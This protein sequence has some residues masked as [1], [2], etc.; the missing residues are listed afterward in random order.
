MQHHLWILESNS[1]V[2]QDISSN[3]K[4]KLLLYP[5]SDFSKEPQGLT[6]ITQGSAG[7]AAPPPLSVSLHPF[8]QMKGKT[9]I[10]S[11]LHPLCTHKALAHAFL[12][13]WEHLFMPFSAPT[14]SPSHP[15]DL[16]S[17]FWCTGVMSPVLPVVLYPPLST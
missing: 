4:D 6:W 13:F 10:H 7:M 2:G 8:S 15:P 1:R 16:S 9:K 11:S 5:E 17:Y 12:F 14:S 3:V